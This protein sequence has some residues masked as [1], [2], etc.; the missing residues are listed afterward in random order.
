[1]EAFVVKAYILIQALPATEG[2]VAGRIAAEVHWVVRADDTTGGPCNV[3][4]YAEAPTVD[5]MD[6]MVVTPIQCMENVTQT[7]TCW[8]P[9]A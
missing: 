7:V 4:A 3:I 1:M 9:H 6:H 2:L 8:L 5:D